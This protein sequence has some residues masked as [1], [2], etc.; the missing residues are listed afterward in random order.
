[1]VIRSS[2]TSGFEREEERDRSPGRRE[3]GEACERY[4]HV[5]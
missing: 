5:Y 1:V 3:P 4:L 2:S